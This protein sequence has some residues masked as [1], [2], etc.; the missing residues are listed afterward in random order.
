MLVRA[1]AFA[2]RSRSSPSTDPTRLPVFMQTWETIEQ[3][4]TIVTLG[5][6]LI[7]ELRSLK[8]ESAVEIPAQAP[9]RSCEPGRARLKNGRRPAR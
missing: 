5:I 1:A 2:E 6:K 3:A 9:K 8:R 4:L 7:R